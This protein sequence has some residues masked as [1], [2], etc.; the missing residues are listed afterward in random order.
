MA[1]EVVDK[2]ADNMSTFCLVII[3]VE[4]DVFVVTQAFNIKSMC[5]YSRYC[6]QT[7]YYVKFIVSLSLPVASTYSCA[8]L[9]FVIVA[10][11]LPLSLL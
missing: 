1:V 10:L 9:L 11:P 5:F 7:L 8:H 6:F 4:I 3:I 2:A